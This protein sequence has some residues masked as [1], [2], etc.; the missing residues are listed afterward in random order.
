MSFV[1]QAASTSRL[2][3]ARRS[4]ASAAVR[5]QAVPAEKELPASKKT[6]NKEFKIYRW[7]R[8]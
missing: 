1:R 3:A 5:A 8:T 4:F 6:L 2:F 7:V